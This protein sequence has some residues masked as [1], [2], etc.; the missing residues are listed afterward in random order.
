MPVLLEGGS[1]AIDI[2]EY[3]RKAFLVA[4]VAA[5]RAF[6]AG[7]ALHRAQAGVPVL[8]EGTLVGGGG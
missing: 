8:L 3:E 5:L 6:R 1:Y 4:A 2:E 7:R